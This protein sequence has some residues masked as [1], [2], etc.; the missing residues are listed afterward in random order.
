MKWSLDNRPVACADRSRERSSGFAP[1]SRT[2]RRGAHLGVRPPQSGL[3]RHR[4]IGHRQQSYRA[5]DR[6][7]RQRSGRRDRAALCARSAA[8]RVHNCGCSG[9]H[10]AVLLA[11]EM[12]LEDRCSN[13]DPYAQPA[14]SPVL[15]V[16][17]L[18]MPAPMRR[19]R[20]SSPPMSTRQV[21]LS[22]QASGRAKASTYL[23]E[24]QGR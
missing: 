14:A 7:V 24:A 21:R 4:R 16:P 8:P 10:V 23:R 11:A 18:I 3:I 6:D 15:G 19:P 13:Q 2:S 5:S 17:A 9:D 12:A 20:G 22:S 1:I